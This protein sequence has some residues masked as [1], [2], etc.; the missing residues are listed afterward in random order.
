MRS[1]RSER[2]VAP[3]VSKLDR[4]FAQATNQFEQS[5]C[6]LVMS[7][8]DTGTIAALE[9]LFTAEHR[10]QLVSLREDPGVL[11]VDTVLAELAKLVTLNSFGVGVNVFA[12]FSS[13]VIERWQARFVGGSAEPF[14]G[15]DATDTNVDHVGVGHVSASQG[16]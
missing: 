5:A 3:A 13:R 4:L 2:V 14:R 15:Y 6:A 11:G 8:L 7:R 16:D 9:V 1:C 10:E 12:G